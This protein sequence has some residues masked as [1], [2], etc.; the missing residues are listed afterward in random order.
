MTAVGG[1]HSQAGALADVMR[2]ITAEKIAGV[3]IGGVAA[4]PNEIETESVD[5]LRAEPRLTSWR[6]HKRTFQRRYSP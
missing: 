1:L 5:E 4:S 3:V 2:W 6:I